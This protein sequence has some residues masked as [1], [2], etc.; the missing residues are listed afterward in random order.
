M[1][2]RSYGCLADDLA[3]GL[4]RNW[5]AQRLAV[6][7]ASTARVAHLAEPLRAAAPPVDAAP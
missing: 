2:D 1:T 5:Q 6:P 3:E 7:T 4:A